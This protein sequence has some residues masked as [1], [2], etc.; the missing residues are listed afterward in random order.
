MI[1]K[2]EGF[3]LSAKKYGEKALIVTLFT[4]NRGKITGFVAEGTGKKNIGLF[5][6]GNK[7][8]FESS[9]RLEENMCRLFRIELMEPNAVNMMT[10][11]KRLELMSATIPMI[12]RLLNEN[13]ETFTLYNILSNFFHAKDIKE[14]LTWYAY[15]EFYALEYLGLG[16]S[17]D[18]CAVTGVTENLAYVSPKSGKAVCKEVGAPYHDRLFSY[19]HFIVDK[20]DTPSYEEIFN[21]LRMTEFF[22]NQNFFKFHNLRMPESRLTLW[23]FYEKEEVNNQYQEKNAVGF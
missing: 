2:D 4:L 3:C 8:F 7:L 23:Q 22:L 1:I 5:Q 9:A 10:D 6:P 15:F 18:C 17:L 13:E 21:V 19:P 20:N 16:L 12:L 11:I 14:M